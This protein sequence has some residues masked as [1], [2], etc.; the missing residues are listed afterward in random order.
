[1]NA[2]KVLYKETKCSEDQADFYIENFGPSLFTKVGPSRI[3]S[4]EFSD[5]VS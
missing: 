3:S 4:V 5:S 1:M 2:R